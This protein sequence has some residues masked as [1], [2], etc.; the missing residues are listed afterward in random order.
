MLNSTCSYTAAFYTAAGQ[1]ITNIEPIRHDMP[2]DLL[3][4]HYEQQSAQLITVGLNT[5]LF[6]VR[7][8]VPIRK[9]KQGLQKRK[10]EIRI[11]IY[12][13]ACVSKE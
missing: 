6:S 4:A 5:A 10:E 12:K 13:S 2:L 9:T 8:P 7:M 11:L 3:I 1:E